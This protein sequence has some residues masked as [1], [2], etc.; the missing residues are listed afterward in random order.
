MLAS[1]RNYISMMTDKT[2]ELEMLTQRAVGGHAIG[3]DLV[4]QLTHSG[5]ALHRASS[6]LVEA[7]DCLRRID[8]P[9]ESRS[10]GQYG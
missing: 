3:D 7:A 10:E 6:R 1:A 8:I 9:Q 5:E 2:A 4:A